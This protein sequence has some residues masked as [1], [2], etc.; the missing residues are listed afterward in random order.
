[1]RSL[2]FGSTFDGGSF[3]LISLRLDSGWGGGGGPNLAAFFC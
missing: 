3:C 1:M 2:S